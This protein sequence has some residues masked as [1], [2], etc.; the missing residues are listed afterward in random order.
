MAAAPLRFGISGP[1]LFGI[2]VLD[3][4]TW[5]LDSALGLVDLK[6]NGL[7]KMASA[8]GCQRAQYD[9]M[10]LQESLTDRIVSFLSS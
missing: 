4:R 1:L 7:V 6:Q 3:A 10:E 8:V 2:W 9:V 5:D